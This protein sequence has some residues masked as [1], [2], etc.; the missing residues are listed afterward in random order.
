MWT[1]CPDVTSPATS[2]LSLQCYTPPAVPSD[3]HF[4]S[5]HSHLPCSHLAPLTSTSPPICPPAPHSLI[6]RSLLIPL[7]VLC[8]SVSL[9]LLLCCC[10]ALCFCF[11]PNVN[12]LPV[13]LPASF[14]LSL[15][16]LL[17][18]LSAFCPSSVAA[19]PH[20]CDTYKG[21]NSGF[22]FLSM[23]HTEQFTGRIRQRAENKLNKER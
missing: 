17:F 18:R 20:Y 12:L 5:C 22:K 6:S 1:H 14:F 9:S 10:L 15:N 3:C 13:Y 4:R 8:S 21:F 2:P 7:R 19:L 11:H 23:L 16:H